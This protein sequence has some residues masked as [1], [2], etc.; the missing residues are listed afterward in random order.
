MFFRIAIPAVLIAALALVACDDQS[1]PTTAPTITLTPTPVTAPSA[2]SAPKKT[3]ATALA[4]TPVPTSTSVSAPTLTPTSPVV[5]TS[6][7]AAALPPSPPLD[8]ASSGQ[9]T[10]PCTSVPN[11]AI[12]PCELD[13]P[14][15]DTTTAGF[16]PDLGDAPSGV[17]WMLEDARFRRVAHLV[18]RATYLPNTVRCTS[19]DPFRP[20]FN[21]ADFSD[22]TES[23]L[24]DYL[25]DIYS[26]KC[27]TDMRVNAYILGHRSLNIERDDLHS[28]IP[29]GYFRDRGQNRGRRR[30]RIK[31]RT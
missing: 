2:V 27:F 1:T 12:D 18:V 17:R 16:I 25:G 7:F 19:G 15:S 30:G 20:P 26:L 13:A 23:D 4:P 14:R 28:R 5:A 21:A 6:T 11:A 8:A 31:A 10:P 29:G 24:V 22:V 9:N 3:P